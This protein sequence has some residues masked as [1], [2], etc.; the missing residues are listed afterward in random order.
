M[1]AGLGVAWWAPPALWYGGKEAIDW[2]LPEPEQ[3]KEFLESRWYQV[4]PSG[5]E[6]LLLDPA[7]WRRLRSTPGVTLVNKPYKSVQIK[8]EEQYKADDQVR[9]AQEVAALL[10]SQWST[11]ADEQTPPPPPTVERPTTAPETSSLS[12]MDVILGGVILLAVGYGGFFYLR[13]RK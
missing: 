7:E 10:D 4:M 13:G 3:D 9:A 1:A 11:P 6:R 12:T 2:A 5:E 8:S